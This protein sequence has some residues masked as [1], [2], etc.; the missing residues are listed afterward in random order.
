MATAKNAH[1]DRHPRFDAQSFQ[2]VFNVFMNG[3]RADAKYAG[4]D[5]IGLAFADPPGNLELARA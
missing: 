2:D 4:D 3:A 5:G 1:G